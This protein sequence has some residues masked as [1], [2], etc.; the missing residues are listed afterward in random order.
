MLYYLTYRGWMYW[1]MRKG[2]HSVGIGANQESVQN[3]I[4]ERK[5]S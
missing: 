4:V 5:K 3:A 1:F 2:T